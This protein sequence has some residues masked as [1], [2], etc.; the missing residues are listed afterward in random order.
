MH[1][2][3]YGQRAVS[4]FFRNRNAG[5]KRTRKRVPRDTPCGYCFDN[6]ATG[7]DHIIPISQGGGNQDENLYP[8]C[9]RCNSLLHDKLFSSIE[10]KREYV[11]TTLIERGQWSVPELREE[12]YA[13]A[14]VA[15][16]LLERVPMGTMEQSAPTCRNC[17]KIL[18]NLTKVKVFCSRNCGRANA[19]DKKRIAKEIRAS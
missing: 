8:S 19:R 16:V 15:E 11:R 10:E 2:M 4:G 1:C 18:I 12:V 17:G 6:W 9:K 13:E 7:W 3:S 14:P 5:R